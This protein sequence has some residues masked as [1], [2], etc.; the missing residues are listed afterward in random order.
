MVVIPFSIQSLQRAAVAVAAKTQLMGQVVD[1]VEAG[2]ATVARGAV[3]LVRADKAMRVV[4]ALVDLIRVAG[5]A[6]LALWAAQAPF[7]QRGM[8]EP[9]PVVPSAVDQLIM[10]GAVVAERH[11][12][13]QLGMVPLAAEETAAIAQGVRARRGSPI[14]EEEAAAVIIML[15]AAAGQEVMGSFS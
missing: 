12:V 7:Q 14:V 5:V 8:A 10:A 9:A 13:R 6:A 3:A 4:M 1:L 11:L 15:A 2:A